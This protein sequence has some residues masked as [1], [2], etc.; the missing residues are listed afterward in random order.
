M[1]YRLA[2]AVC[3]ALVLGCSTGPPS[4]TPSPAGSSRST[5]ADRSA[6]TAASREF[7]VGGDRPVTVQVPASYDEGRPAPLL[8]V[9]HGYG[10]TGPDHDG[11]FHLDDAIERRGMI[12][13]YPDGTKDDTGSQFWNGTDACCDIQRS[14]VDDSKYLVGVIAAIKAQVAVDPKRVYVIGHSNGAF[15]SYRVACDHADVVAAIVSLAGATYADDADCHPTA[16]VSV[17]EI[18]G[19]ADDAVAFGGGSVSLPGSTKPLHAYPG[20]KQTVKT[21]ATYDGCN[22][23]AKRSPR[24][25]DVDADLPYAGAPAEATI[26]TWAGCRNGAAVELW[27]MPDG[28]HVPTIS[29]AFPGAVLDFLLAH[30]KA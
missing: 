22:P 9:L 1:K 17:L 2:T 7:V 30:P 29:N 28:V 5:D 20:A 26:D 24:H 8:I 25:V 4:A 15:M 10:S 12:S 13:A 19:T 16:A 6:S 11:Y 18:H 23:T 27:T 3:A 14:G 21:W